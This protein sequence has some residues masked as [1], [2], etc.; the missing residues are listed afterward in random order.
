MK[1]K[2]WR[3]EFDMGTDKVVYYR[4]CP[5]EKLDGEIDKLKAE[6]PGYK[7][8]IYQ[9]VEEKLLELVTSGI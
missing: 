5:V 8:I 3:I 7:A 4:K 1:V 6:C 9:V 2:L